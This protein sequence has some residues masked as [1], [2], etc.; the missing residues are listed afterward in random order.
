MSQKSKAANVNHSRDDSL[1]ASI[2]YVSTGAQKNAVLTIQAGR[3]LRSR[4]EARLV[5]YL[6]AITDKRRFVQLASGVVRLI[7]FH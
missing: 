5:P 1:I 2:K 7:S 4:L 6:F 3:A